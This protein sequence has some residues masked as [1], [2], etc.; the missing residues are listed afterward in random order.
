MISLIAAMSNNCV[1]GA[2]NTIPWN[3]KKDLSIFRKY[4][5]GSSVI[6]GKNTWLSLNQKPLKDRNNI[7]VSKTLKLEYSN[8]LS[9]ANCLECAIT[10][11][12]IKSNYRD[13]WIIGGASI[14]KEALE[15]K[16]PERL[17]ISKM[18]F[19]VE[20]DTYFPS[21]PKCYSVS[22]IRKINDDFSIYTYKRIEQ[23]N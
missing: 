10:Q 13:A 21:I 11:F 19:D 7:V 14:Y 5:I 20:G 23:L 6:M 8:S 12:T 3:S 4:T 2:N 9:T 18:N 22:D 17:I 1:I 16:I 15:K